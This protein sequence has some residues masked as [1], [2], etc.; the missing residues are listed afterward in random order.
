MGTLFIPNT[1]CLIKGSPNPQA[2][3]KLLDHL[4]SA[5]VEAVLAKGR[6]AQFPVNP[7]VDF[8]SRAAADEETRWMEV[9]FSAAAEQ[10]TTAAEFLRDLF[11]TAE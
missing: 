7:E 5:D 9:D 6:S 4:L 1:L 3:R 11:A 2:A 10:W 8:Q